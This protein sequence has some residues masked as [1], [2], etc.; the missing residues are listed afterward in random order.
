MPY[1]V[2]IFM[3]YPDLY[4]QILSFWKIAHI[5]STLKLEV[6]DTKT[7]TAKIYSG[8]NECQQSNGVVT[9]F[10]SLKLHL[11]KLSHR[12]LSSFPKMT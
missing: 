10:L 11:R 3:C 4:N 9:I 5:L 6:T 12:E 7:D 1:V 8:V 2:L